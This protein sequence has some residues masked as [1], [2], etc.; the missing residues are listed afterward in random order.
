V[1]LHYLVKC[2]CH[3]CNNENKTTSVT[4]HFKKCRTGNNN[5][6]ATVISC[7]RTF[8]YVFA[9][10]TGETMHDD[11]TAVSLNTA[12]LFDPYN[13]WYRHHHHQHHCAPSSEAAAT[14][15]HR[16]RSCAR[17]RES[18]SGRHVS[19]LTNLAHSH[20]RKPLIGFRLRFEDLL[21]LENERGHPCRA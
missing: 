5:S 14:A 3:E 13:S 6:C 9:N 12:V 15:L 20:G 4:T 16:F 7:L 11:D 18:I 2:Q 10:K 19:V 17:V 21:R 8:S 1:S